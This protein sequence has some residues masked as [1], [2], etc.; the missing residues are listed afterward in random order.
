VTVPSRAL[1][2]C[3]GHGVSGCL[4]KVGWPWGV[5]E[6]RTKRIVTSPEVSEESC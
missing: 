3:P 2:P 6:T 5:D 4:I 1:V